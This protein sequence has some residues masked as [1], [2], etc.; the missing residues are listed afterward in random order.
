MG[1][2]VFQSITIVILILSSSIYFNFIIKIKNTI[3]YDIKFL[4]TSSARDVETAIKD[5]IYDLTTSEY[6]LKSIL[7]MIFIS[8]LMTKY[9][10]IKAI[11]NRIINFNKIYDELIIFISA[12]LVFSYILYTQNILADTQLILSLQFLN[13]DKKIIN[14][15]MFSFT[16][17]NQEIKN[18]III[19]FIIYGVSWCFAIKV[20]IMTIYIK[21]RSLTQFTESTQNT[22]FINESN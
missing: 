20:I 19:G 12:L 11:S 7:F 3:E 21:Y 4:N 18:M 9:T 15:F 14:L 10:T 2:F 8:Y 6:I 1:L 16:N 13:I 22:L 5:I 17:N